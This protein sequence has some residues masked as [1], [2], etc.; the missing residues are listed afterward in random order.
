MS[1][2]ARLRKTLERLFVHNGYYKL[3]SAALVF[4]LYTWIS[5]ERETQVPVFASVRM[6]VPKHLVLTS[7]PVDRVRITVQGRFS[8]LNKLSDDS[9]EPLIVDLSAKTPKD[10]I[11]RLSEDMVKLPPGLR[12]ASLQ[13]SFIRITLKERATRTVP[14][15]VR[16]VG[17]PPEGILVEE[18]RVSP[19]QVTVSGPRD[20]VEQTRVALTEP[21]DLS[22]R[23][24]TFT[25][26]VELRHSDPLL[27]DELGGPAEVR[28]SL[29]TRAVER[30]IEGLPVIAVNT[31]LLAEVS[32]ATVTLTLRGP[33]Q[34]LKALR[35]EE[36]LAAIDLG[37]DGAQPG[38]Y[39]RPVSVRNLPRDVALL[40]THPTD[41]R[42][43]TRRPPAPREDD[44]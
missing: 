3:L 7:P 33:E 40:A 6:A 9:V 1:L 36:L 11:V 22:D 8:G 10:D 37:S 43:T 21:V 17:E 29:R 25:E 18:L 16:T 39:L 12:V 2:G 20:L 41:F 5:A 27:S 42:V 34:L 4:I 28:V 14:V 19:A 38:T 44:R 31:S 23:K 13:P 30:A 24:E 15:R 26:R 32:P 35:K